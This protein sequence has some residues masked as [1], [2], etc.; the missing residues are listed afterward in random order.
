M[1]TTTE[2]CIDACNSLLRGELSAIETYRQALEKFS[3]GASG[4]V[5]REILAGHEENA[6]LIREHI[7]S[8]D[9]GEPATDSG[10]WGLFARAVEGSAKLLGESAA[11][12]ALQEGE[13]HGMGEYEEA[14]ESDEVMEEMKDVI[15]ERLRPS[16]AGHIQQLEALRA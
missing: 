13:E 1:N 11:L 14:L 4:P 3:G 15:R 2:S 7:L 16:L 6:R 10:V 9:G 5:L 8:M 12:K